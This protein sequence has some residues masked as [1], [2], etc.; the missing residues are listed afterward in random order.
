MSV[1]SNHCKFRQN[2]SDCNHVK[3]GSLLWLNVYCPFTFRN[4]A[5]WL[6]VIFKKAKAVKPSHAFKNIA[7]Y[8][9]IS[10][11]VVLDSG[12]LSGKTNIEPEPS[13]PRLSRSSSISA[14][15]RNGCFCFDDMTSLA[16]EIIS[17]DQRL[18][19]PLVSCC[20]GGTPSWS[21]YKLIE[22]WRVVNVI[23][24]LTF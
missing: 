10:A 17:E 12:I 24:L 6:A 4:V 18:I 23:K 20:C 11:W 3:Y 13:S 16:N 1:A 15:W 5:S 2:Y 19:L 22:Y 7:G 8:W 9:Q 14:S 21:N